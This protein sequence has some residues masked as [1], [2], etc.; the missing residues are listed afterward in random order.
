[1]LASRLMARVGVAGTPGAARYAIAARIAIAAVVIGVFLTWTSD[2]PVTLNGTQGPN[3]GWLAVIVAAFALGWTR[4][5]RRGSWIGIAGVLGAAVVVA[6]TA[7]ENWLDNRD[8][9]G[10]TASYG[11]VVVVAASVVLAAA[12]VATAVQ[13]A[14]GD[15]RDSRREPVVATAQTTSLKR[16]GRTTVDT[17]SPYAIEIA[18]TKVSNP[19]VIPLIV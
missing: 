1:M 10:A 6:W 5:L 14:R 11:L 19:A 15:T 13:R 16:R 17:M 18:V 9:F 8:A 7:V 3:N 12:A 2:E 4:S